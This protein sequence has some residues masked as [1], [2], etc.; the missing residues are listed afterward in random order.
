MR[1]LILAKV[2]MATMGGESPAIHLT[3][4]APAGC[5][6]RAAFVTAIEQRTGAIQTDDA[7]PLSVEVSIEAKSDGKATGKL[8][9]ADEAPRVASADS[10]REVVDALAV[11]AALAIEAA[12]PA[13][14]VE[15]PAPPPTP[16]TPP[17]AR[18]T[19]PF[20]VST[21]E[22]PDPAKRIG[23]VGM[24]VAHVSTVPTVGSV[25]GFGG[26][27]ELWSDARASSAYRLTVVRTDTLAIGELAPLA[28][29]R[30][31]WARVEA[32]PLRIGT[33]F[34]LQPCVGATGGVLESGAGPS[35]T[36]ESRTRPWLALG[37]GLRAATGGEPWI[38]SIEAGAVAPLLRDTFELERSRATYRVPAILLSFAAGVG[39]RFR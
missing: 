25:V 7:A 30:W 17:V 20:E 22:E 4:D 9:I 1:A 28:W 8:R 36:I 15:E 19:T 32:C 29:Q 12:P 38:V 14:P 11:I 24:G 21:R 39:L 35:D 13:S 31:T 18:D 34:A 16:A 2:L 3:Y 23:L 37:A 5:P 27:F 6:D 33:G 10:C 26:V